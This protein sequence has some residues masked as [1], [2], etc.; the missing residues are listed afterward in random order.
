VKNEFEFNNHIISRWTAKAW[1]GKIDFLSL[2][3]ATRNSRVAKPMQL[4]SE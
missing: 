3:Y 2:G 1:L 4:T